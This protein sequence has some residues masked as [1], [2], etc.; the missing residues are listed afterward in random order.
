MKEIN[1]RQR[2]IGATCKII[3]FQVRKYGFKIINIIISFEKTEIFLFAKN[4]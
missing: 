4:I 3:E 1:A 2:V